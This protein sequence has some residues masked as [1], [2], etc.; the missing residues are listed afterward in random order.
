M[1]VIALLQG[2]GWRG[3]KEHLTAPLSPT[4][5]PMRIGRRESASRFPGASHLVA[6]AQLSPY[7]CSQRPSKQTLV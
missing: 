3:L 5:P 4:P 1:L 2:G 6:L 7:L